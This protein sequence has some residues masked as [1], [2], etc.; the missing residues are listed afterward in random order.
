MKE[1]CHQVSQHLFAQD[2]LTRFKLR[3][4]I[5]FPFKKIY[6]ALLEFRRIILKWRNR[7][8]ALIADVHQ[9]SRS[10]SLLFEIIVTIDWVALLN[11]IL[12]DKTALRT[13]NGLDNTECIFRIER[14]N[15]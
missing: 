12:I 15:R 2:E 8:M 9:A 10:F 14:D 4:K 7:I 13:F 5:L 11:E 1:A 3:I 6:F